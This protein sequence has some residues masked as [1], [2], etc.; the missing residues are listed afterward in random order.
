MKVMKEQATIVLVA[1]VWK[2][3][4]LVAS[5]SQ[6]VLEKPSSP[7]TN[8]WSSIGPYKPSK[9][10]P[11][12]PKV[13]T[14]YLFH[15]RQRYENG[16]LSQKRIELMLSAHPKSN[17]KTYQSA[18]KKWDSWCCAMEVDPICSTLRDI[19][20]FLTDMFDKGHKHH[21]INVLKSVLSS[22]HEKIDGFRV[23]SHPDVCLLLKGISTQWPPK[24]KYS[25]IWNV[26]EVL[27]YIKNM[28]ENDLKQLTLK[29]FFLVAIT[30]PERVDILESLKWS[31]SVVKQQIVG[32]S[33]GSAMEKEKTFSRTRKTYGYFILFT[34]Q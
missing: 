2:T 4:T 16:G 29:M 21:V 6:N 26:S 12:V 8:Q 17:H 11:I 22:V 34:G 15:I 33:F 13:N 14:G 3:E 24:P 9:N 5:P 20:H 27:T 30:C 25:C 10:S 18:W 23:G 31:L 1:P 7:T 28:G 32:Y 19:L